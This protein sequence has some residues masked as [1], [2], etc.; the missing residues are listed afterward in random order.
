LVARY[1]GEEFAVIFTGID[2]A[3]ARVILDTA[4]ATVQTK[5]YRLRESD[6]PLGEVTFSAGL[7][8]ARADEMCSTVFQ[9]AD[10]LLYAA[11]EGGRNQVRA[12]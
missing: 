3:A 5:N 7:T 12:D 2:A 6:A 4:R 9:R 1:G 8:T 11:K 10:R